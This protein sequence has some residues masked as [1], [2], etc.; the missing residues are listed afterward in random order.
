VYNIVLNEMPSTRPNTL[1][2]VNTLFLVN[3]RMAIFR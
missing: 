3:D 1:I 2:R